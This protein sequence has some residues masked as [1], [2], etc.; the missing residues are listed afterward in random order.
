MKKIKEPIL[1]EDEFG[2]IFKKNLPGYEVGDEL[3][4][5]VLTLLKKQSLPYPHHSFF[6]KQLNF[7]RLF[8]T[9]AAFPRF[10]AM[11][12]ALG[13]VV[14]SVL[15]YYKNYAYTYPLRQARLSLSELQKILDPSLEQRSSWILTTYADE[16]IDVNES[17]IVGLSHRIFNLTE[18]AMNLAQYLTNSERVETA[19]IKIQ[20]VQMDSMDA[21]SNALLKLNKADDIKAVLAVIKST[22]Q[23]Q[24]QVY[25]VI[26]VAQKAKQQ[27]HKKAIFAIQ[28]TQP[29][30]PSFV[31]K[32]I[33][34]S[35]PQKTTPVPRS[36]VSPSQNQTNIK[37]NP[38][39]L[40]PSIIQTEATDQFA[41]ALKT[42]DRLKTAQT[43]R[44]SELKD[45]RIKINKIETALNEERYHSAQGLSIAVESK[46]KAILRQK[47]QRSIP[48]R[49]GG[50]KFPPP[51]GLTSDDSEENT[52]TEDKSSRIKFRDR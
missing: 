1:N 23:E 6:K 8:S 3:N 51:A 29:Q 36:K 17:E 40:S 39:D 52:L 44:V 30:P 9:W 15:F 5:K 32:K 24:D 11:S 49:E 22:S 10:L 34:L 7:F 18:R 35:R 20:D 21:F 25:Q 31:F 4:R 45:L 47:R 2:Q 14:T 26:E 46:G 37:N 50:I 13:I 16:F 42:Y 27:G 43:A 38:T 48:L 33:P 41:S 28:T 19:F 12:M